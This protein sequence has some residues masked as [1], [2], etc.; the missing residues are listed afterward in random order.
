M[1]NFD[2]VLTAAHKTAE[3]LGLSWAAV[4]PYYKALQESSGNDRSGWLPKSVGRSIWF[5]HP[6]FVTR[7]LVAVAATTN[8]ADAPKVMGWVKELVPQGYE[9]ARPEISIIES[10]FHKYLVNHKA[11][12]KLSNVEIH[13][14]TKTVAFN[15]KDGEAVIYRPFDSEQIT[16]TSG[17]MNLHRRGIID[18]RAFELLAKS[19]N[20]RRDDDL[21][22]MHED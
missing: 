12:E 22:M 15:L 21:P 6:N 16:T 4:Q 9:G 10:E 7:L 3:S 17:A 8:P 14:D 13:P 1:D 11:A 2:S 19:V 20:W 5:A 18:G